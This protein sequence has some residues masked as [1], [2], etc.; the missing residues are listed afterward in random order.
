MSGGHLDPE[1]TARILHY[2]ADC[3]QYYERVS[4]LP[5]CNDCGRN[6]EC[7]YLPKPG[8]Q[9]RINC[10]LHIS[11]HL[12]PADKEANQQLLQDAT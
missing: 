3:I 1:R 10:P 8:E 5:D 6:P 9:V 4:C 11:Q 2:I 7:E 12:A